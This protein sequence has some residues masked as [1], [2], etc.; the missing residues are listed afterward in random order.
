MSS[1]GDVEREPANQG[2]FGTCSAYAMW[3]IVTELLTLKYNVV[4]PFD[5]NIDSVC[6]ICDA[7]EGS[8][9]EHNAKA[10]TEGKQK[11]QNIARTMRYKIAV[12]VSEE[13]NDFDTLY[14]AVDRAKGTPMIYIVV[15]TGRR[16]HGHHAIAGLRPHTSPARKEVL[17]INS[18]GDAKARYPCT[19]DNLTRFYVVD[20]KITKTWN[21]KG[22]TSNPPCREGAQELIDGLLRNEMPRPTP[23]P[24]PEPSLTPEQMYEKGCDYYYGRNGVAKDFKQAVF[25]YRKSA[26]QGN[27]LGQY[28]LG[29]CYKNGQGI[30]K[31]F[32][33]AVFWF[34]KSADQGNKDAK[35]KL[36]ESWAQP[37][38]EPSPT[39]SPTPEPSL[40]PE[41]MNKKGRDYY[42]GRNGVAKDYKQAVFWYRKSAD[43]GNNALGQNSIGF[44]YFNG[45]GVVKDLEQAVFW[46]R[47]SADQNNVAGQ[48]KLGDCYYKGQGV[49]QD[50]KQAE[51]WY[52]KSAD[53]GNA[54]G[55]YYLGHCCENGH[56]VTK[57]HKQAVYWYRKSAE[58]GN[59]LGQNSLGFC[60]KNGQGVVE[61]FKQAVF[62]YGK[63]ADQGNAVAKERL[64]ESW[65]QPY[66]EPSPTAE[67]TPEPSLAPDQMNEKGD[68]Y[69]Y[70]RNGVAKDFKQA[71]FWYRKSASAIQGHPEA[72]SN[73]GYCYEKGHGVPKDY[74]LAR[75]WY[76]KS[77]DQGFALGQYNLGDCCYNGWGDAKDYKEA[78][79]WFLK[80]K[81][82]GDKDAKKKL[83]ESWARPY[84]EEQPGIIKKLGST[85]WARFFATLNPTE[86]FK[87]GENYYHGLNGV[88]V[89]YK[90]AV[91]WYRK[92]AEQRHPEAMYR[93]GV[94][95]YNGKGVTKDFKE[96]VSW[97]RESAEQGD[98]WGQYYLG[99]CYK[100]GNG[101]AKDYE[102]AVSWYRR[103][104]EQGN[105]L[106]NQMLAKSWAQ[107]YLERC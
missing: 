89:D 25:W 96:A 105:K 64:S 18:W 21:S 20:V 94:C 56:G 71:V 13:Q 102:Q 97:Y 40:T 23:S 3:R 103:S 8:N 14:A 59:A 11:F 24:T 73:L 88:A 42:K 27:A 65:A 92:S 39:P 81:E 74:K 38:L 78:V 90:Q 99:Q 37:Y 34:H 2:E 85:I 93:L 106:A 36:S 28:R 66:L 22:E 43:Q 17:C 61:D 76:K 1:R 12:T 55:Q 29:F 107:P 57:D 62:W 58:Q 32:K 63:S 35:K 50:F 98:A 101:V 69:Y 87:K 79:F 70:G 45:L 54:L 6:D 84:L 5:R 10:I 100:Y 52:R 91:Y 95:Y 51:F 15:T 26:D 83:R 77:A 72:Q 41:K 9:A 104:E 68:D 82:Q 4:V 60:Y 48:N 31:D 7:Y 75:Y 30:T 19:R 46:Y 53:Q 49:D 67:P 33:Q 47:K 80:S 86:M 44:C 16:G